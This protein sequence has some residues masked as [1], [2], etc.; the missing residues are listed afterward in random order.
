MNVDKLA[1]G[2]EQLSNEI[3]RMRA[4]GPLSVHD[5]Q[6]AASTLTRAQLFLNELERVE[7]R[8]RGVSTEMAERFVVLENCIRTIRD[9]LYREL[10]Y[11]R[12][13]P[14]DGGDAKVSNAGVGSHNGNDPSGR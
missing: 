12:T 11:R 10:Q 6:Q 2:I 9:E 7:L 14:Q 1:Q 4:S 3:S 13:S 5:V 8:E